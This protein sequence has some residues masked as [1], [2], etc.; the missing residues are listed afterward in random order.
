M[1][2]FTTHKLREIA[3]IKISY[4]ESNKKHYKVG[5]CEEQMGVW[6]AHYLQPLKHISSPDTP[7]NPLGCCSLRAS[8]PLAL[9]VIKF[10]E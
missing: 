2:H 4:V 8:Q 9:F 5:L 7:R 3:G 6:H 10:L 1:L